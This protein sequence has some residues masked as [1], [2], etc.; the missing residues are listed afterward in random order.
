MISRNSSVFAKDGVISVEAE[1]LENSLVGGFTLKPAKDT[2]LYVKLL[3]PKAIA[4][5]LLYLSDNEAG[6]KLK[7]Y[8]FKNFEEYK[9]QELKKEKK[10]EAFKKNKPSPV[11]IRLRTHEEKTHLEECAANENMKVSSFIYTVLKKHGY[12]GGDEISEEENLEPNEIEINDILTEEDK[13]KINKILEEENHQ[14]SFEEAYKI[15]KQKE[16]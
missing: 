5:V 1:T 8:I 7:N 16:E 15:Y 6:N 2:S 4:R 11:S 12:L 3:T 14:I 10:K 13:N 9:M